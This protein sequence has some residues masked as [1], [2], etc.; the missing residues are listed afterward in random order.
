MPGQQS[1]G[2]DNRSHLG[3]KLSSQPFGLNGQST[4]LFIVQAQPSIAELFAKNPVLLAKVI[5]YLY[6]LFVHPAGDG[7]QHEPEWIQDSWHLVSSLL[8]VKC[9]GDEPS[10][11]QTDPVSGPYGRAN[12]NLAVELSKGRANVACSRV[13]DIVQPDLNYN[14]GFIRACR[15]ARLARA[16]KM[17]IVPHNTQTGSSA[18]NILQ[19]ASAIPNAGPYVEFPWRGDEKRE[20]WYTAQFEIRNGVIPVPT[21][22]GLGI[23]FDPAYLQKAEKVSG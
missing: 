14:G 21:G 20:S 19:F 18:V 17:Q 5:N 9:C 4:A 22:P 11:I 2:C 12:G 7:D 23:E 15:V 10:R 13:V 16:A 1:L 8:N 3:Q 6:L